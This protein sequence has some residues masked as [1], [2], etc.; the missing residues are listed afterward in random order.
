MRIDTP[1]RDDVFEVASALRAED[2]RELMASG[3]AKGGDLVQAL[4]DKYSKG[5]HPFCVYLDGPVAIA[6]VIPVDET[7]VRVGMFATDEFPRIAFAMTKFVRKT[8]L[9]AYAAEGFKT[10]DCVSIADYTAAHKW[11]KTLGLQPL[12][13]LTGVGTGGE[14]F[15]RFGAD[16]A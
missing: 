13:Q 16:L 8:L 14:D 12:E 4:T 15:I 5:L 7:A 11:L 1:S 9:P 2:Y 3:A 6:A 10:V